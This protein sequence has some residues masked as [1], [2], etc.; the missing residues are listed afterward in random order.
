[1]KMSAWVLASYPPKPCECV[2]D[3][4]NCQG[5]GLDDYQPAHY[6]D[7]FTY[8]LNTLQPP[9]AATIARWISK[10]GKCPKFRIVFT[11]NSDLPLTP[12]RYL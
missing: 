9:P 7:V 6:L 2:G 10:Y 3:H 11:A 12:D 1:M 8:D 4:W 5:T